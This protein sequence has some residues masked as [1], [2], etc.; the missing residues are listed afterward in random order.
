M[1]V[2]EPQY[3]LTAISIGRDGSLDISD[4]LAAEDHRAFHRSISLAKRPDR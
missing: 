4:E 3:V 1:A 2:D